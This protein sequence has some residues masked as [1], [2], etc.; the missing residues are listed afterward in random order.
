MGPHRTAWP[1]HVVQS[2]P[3][4]PRST[5][6]LIRDLLQQKRARDSERAF[7]VE[8]PKPIL[9]ILRDRSAAIQ[10]I[11]VTTAYIE[12]SDHIGQRL[13]ARTQGR[14]YSCRES[15]FEKLSGLDTSQGILAVVRQPV[16]NEEDCLGQN[17]FLGLYGEHLQDPTNV[18]TIIRTAA[19]MNISALWL[20]PD[21]VDVFNPKVV[22][23]TAGALMAL[24]VFR[25]GDVARLIERGCTLLAAD[26]HANG[27]VSI[28]TIQRR[29]A[30]TVLALGN[31]SRGLSDSTLRQAALRFHIPV[32]RNVESLNVAASAAIAMFY[33]S[34][35]PRDPRE[36]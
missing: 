7:V 30:R 29:P 1:S 11:L 20:T 12:R 31:E 13:L 2:L 34:G 27:A 14:A 15:V 28:R 4:L 5:A 18:G 24:P 22:R 8:G 35:L 36:G 16:W 32:S 10:A 6:Q 3:S 25:I 21:S 17:D 23:A 33:F 19:A 9:E 26:S